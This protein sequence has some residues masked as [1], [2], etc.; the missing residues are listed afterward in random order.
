MYP[1]TKVLLQIVR[2]KDKESHQIFLEPE[3]RSV[4]ELYLQVCSSFPIS[5][6]DSPLF[7]WSTLSYIVLLFCL[8]LSVCESNVCVLLLNQ[9]LL[10]LDEKPTTNDHLYIFIRAFL[11]GFLRDCNCPLCELY[12]G[13][14]TV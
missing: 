1:L 5:I 12:Q 9:T 10:F 14:R 2:F 4:P 13:W 7:L 8:S 6:H 3:G 11:L